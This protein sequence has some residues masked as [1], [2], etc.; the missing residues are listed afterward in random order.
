MLVPGAR[1]LSPYRPT[2]APGLY[3]DLP[4]KI[5]HDQEGPEPREVP[6]LLA[7]I[8]ARLFVR[9]REND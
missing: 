7:T 5:L 9:L 6:R 4:A 8:Q 2:R 1:I 3:F